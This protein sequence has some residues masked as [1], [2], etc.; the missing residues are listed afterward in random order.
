MRGIACMFMTA[1][2]KQRKMEEHF[3]VRTIHHEQQEN[4]AVGT[5][6]HQTN[7]LKIYYSISEI[8]NLES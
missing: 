6:M 5:F 3:L 8:E 4:A 2:N 7:L 1:L